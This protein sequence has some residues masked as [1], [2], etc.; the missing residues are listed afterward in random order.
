M[1]DEEYGASGLYG[2]GYGL[3]SLL[4]PVIFKKSIEKR[5]QEDQ[6]QKDISESEKTLGFH[7]EMAK[8]YGM[9]PDEWISQ[10]PERELGNIFKAQK[11]ADRF[12]ADITEQEKPRGIAFTRGIPSQTEST[13]IGALAGSTPSEPIYPGPQ[14]GMQPIGSIVTPQSTMIDP[15]FQIP[16]RK[17]TGMNRKEYRRYEQS[18]QGQQPFGLTPQEYSYEYGGAPKKPGLSSEARVTL[19]DVWKP[20]D[21]M[22]LIGTKEAPLLRRLTP[23]VIKGIAGL[24]TVGQENDAVRF[25]IALDQRLDEAEAKGQAGLPAGERASEILKDITLVAARGVKPEG[26]VIMEQLDPSAR[27][28][29]IELV[30]AGIKGYEDNPNLIGKYDPGEQTGILQFLRTNVP[31]FDTDNQNNERIIG[32]ILDDMFN[33]IVKPMAGKKTVQQLT[34]AEKQKMIDAFNKN[35]TY[36]GF[37][38]T[39]LENFLADYQTYRKKQGQ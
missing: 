3:G 32:T 17:A 24:F 5:K 22:R 9:S 28:L 34:A 2:L 19:A 23:E 21:Y 27:R 31:K 26:M 39:N 12:I 1:A 13:P 20:E 7:M 11:T 30:L 6:K 14:A 4:G 25:I 10:L 37:G 8:N 38:Y 29:Y 33:K 18:V 35:N 36:K 16:E 15:T